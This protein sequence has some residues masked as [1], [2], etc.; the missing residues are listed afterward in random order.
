MTN[1]DVEMTSTL[2][3]NNIN[4]ACFE[5][6]ITEKKVNRNKANVNKTPEIRKKRKANNKSPVIEAAK[7]LDES[8]NDSVF[9]TE[10]EKI[11]SNKITPKRRSCKR[12]RTVVNE[13]MTMTKGDIESFN[14]L[15]DKQPIKKTAVESNK[16]LEQRRKSI[17]TTK[18]CSVRIEKLKMDDFKTSIR[19]KELVVVEN[20]IEQNGKNV[21]K[22]SKKKVQTPR[23]TMT[24][25]TANNK[26]VSKESS[27]KPSVITLSDNEPEVS[28]PV[29][30][31]PINK[32]DTVFAK[33]TLWTD[34]NFYPAIVRHSID[35]DFKVKFSNIDTAVS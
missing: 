23:K 21:A 24:T 25:A 7:N 10:K 2:A 35:S 14:G 30:E 19:L 4:N 34:C 12:Q 6:P 29:L 33:S 20:R 9:E 26:R 16:V 5:T 27:R 15:A 31:L 22:V 17:P 3:N 13:M 28:K 8:D 32:N 11:N 1:S 18:P